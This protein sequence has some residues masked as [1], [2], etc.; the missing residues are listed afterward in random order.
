MV[1]AAGAG[2]QPIHHS[3]LNAETLSKAIRVCNSPQARSTAAT[4]AQKMKAESGVRQAV[5]S[6][7]RNH[8]I[9]DMTCDIISKEPACWSY[10]KGK[11][12]M[13]LSDKAALILTERKKID[14]K[15]LKMSV[16]PH[17]TSKISR[18]K[19]PDC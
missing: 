17:F 7:H 6:F 14:A 13:K 9:N 11:K 5:S 12:D 19:R 18:K 1:Y 10:K 2:P 15:Y 16:E 8:P 4:I 3:Q